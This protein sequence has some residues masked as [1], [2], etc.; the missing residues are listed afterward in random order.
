M[1]KDKK[2]KQSAELVKT[3]IKD[4]TLEQIGASNINIEYLLESGAIPSKLDTPEKLMAVVQTGR[5]LGMNTMTALNNINVIKGRTVISSAMLGAMLKKKGVEFIYTK[6]FKTDEESGKIETEI[7]FEWLSPVTGKPKSTRF[8]VTWGQ[9][10]VAGYT[11]KE[12]WDKYPKEMM[13]ARCMS[14]AVKALFP[15]VTLGVYTE[16]E[17]VDAF[18][19]DDEYKTVVDDEG[20]MRIIP[21]E[22]IEVNEE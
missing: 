5:E 12:N 1:A 20:E 8:G 4:L 18:D 10:E 9:F 22:E 11:E 15:E 21:V 16:G 6:D 14:G 2:E 3:N 7:E 17:I 19:L 13:R